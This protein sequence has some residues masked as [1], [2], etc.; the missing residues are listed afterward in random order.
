MIESIIN[1]LVLYIN[2]LIFYPQKY[3][4]THSMYD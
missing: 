2:H 3:E 1:T 4:L